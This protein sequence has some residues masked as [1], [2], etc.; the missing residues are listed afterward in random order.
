MMTD[1]HENREAPPN[2]G[3]DLSAH[4]AKQLATRFGTPPGIDPTYSG[5]RRAA[6]QPVEAR[7]GGGV[8]GYREPDWPWLRRKAQPSLE[9]GVRTTLLEGRLPEPVPF[10][11][12]PVISSGERLRVLRLSLGW[13][14]RQMAAHLGVH[15]RSLIRHENGRTQ[16][17]RLKSMVPLVEPLKADLRRSSI[18][19][20]PWAASRSER[21]CF[22]ATADPATVAQAADW[23]PCKRLQFI[24]HRSG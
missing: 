21:L 12:A 18:D 14:Q 24:R 7:A 20:S 15:V 23:N 11:L 10:S 5:P 1:D 13:T 22:A 19:E 16:H 8:N 3:Q 4:F 2:D 17:L 6:T 9:N